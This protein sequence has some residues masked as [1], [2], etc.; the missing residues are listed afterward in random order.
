MHMN[1]DVSARIGAL[2]LG[3]LPPSQHDALLEATVSAQPSTQNH[4]PF[5]CRWIGDG[6]L[7]QASSMAPSRPTY[8][9][10]CRDIDD[11][12]LE[13]AVS[14]Q[15]GP[16]QLAVPYCHHIDDS[17]LEEASGMQMGPQTLRK[18]P[19]TLCVG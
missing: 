10:P 15:A 11:G 14:V 8:I 2:E 12:A 5:G 13:A 17:V 16:T 19:N 1:A 4:T 3:I 6:A 9:L 7:E 18:L